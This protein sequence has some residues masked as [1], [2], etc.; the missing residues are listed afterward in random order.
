MNA[1]T[2][3]ML[4]MLG[5]MV[6]RNI[7]ETILQEKKLVEF[8]EKMISLLRAKADATK[9]EV[10]DAAVEALVGFVMEPGNYLDLT[11]QVIA[12]ARQYIG[13]TESELDD[14]F[15]LPII[16]RIETLGMGKA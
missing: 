5:P 8:R 13:H 2:M 14:K 16:D 10:D 12:L 15:L 6:L 4:M 9:N 3:R 7:I 1:V 11:M